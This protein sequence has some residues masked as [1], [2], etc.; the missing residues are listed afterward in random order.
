MRWAFGLLCVFLV[1][2]CTAFSVN[3]HVSSSTLGDLYSHLRSSW[4]DEDPI[5][6]QRVHQIVGLN[7]FDLSDD[8]SNQVYFVSSMRIATDF[9]VTAREQE[10]ILGMSQTDVALL[11]GYFD[12]K[13][14]MGWLD[15]RAGRQYEIDAI[16][17]V[18]Y[19]GLRMRAYTPWYVGMEALG[20]LEAIQD[21]GPTQN[22]QTLDGTPGGPLLLEGRYGDVEPR[23]VI[24]GGLFLHNLQ[25]THLD[26]SYRRIQTL[27]AGTKADVLGKPGVN[28]ERIG[29]AAS[30][31]I[32]EGLFVNGGTSYDFF[33]GGLN[34]IVA[35]ARYR[36][37]FAFEG[38]VKYHYL[39]PSFDADSIW[40]V[41][42]W[43]PMDRVEERARFY[44]SED[45]S[46]HV[47]AYQSFF[48]SDSSVTDEAVENVV[49]DL[50]FNAGGFFR[51]QPDAYARADVNTQFGYG[52][53]QT[54]F[55][56]GMGQE[57]A[58]GTWGIDG[59]ILMIVFE[60]GQ[61]ERLNGTMLGAQLGGFWQFNSDGK[62]SV[63][64]EE[65]SSELQPHWL[66]IFAL[67]DLD[68][69]M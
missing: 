13:E 35:G 48:R 5:Y 9:G 65:A 59:R 21:M 34:E 19:D 10:D 12:M 16:D 50:G 27:G 2:P 64:V 3:Y 46:V 47:G 25:Y 58:G 41:F 63:L 61:Q 7:I 68:F 60:D 42:S 40:N 4:D 57:Y 53:K 15:V 66:R 20:G 24:G 37:V 62:L 69:W 8:G 29:V 38:E 31:R 43:R 49:E 54:F 33:L 22:P 28:Q 51:Y 23:L 56:V 52:G 1:W 14:W 44:G 18:L 36:P 6:R 26:L 39:L 32:T 67:L 11:Y 17:M 30:Q 45:L 55:D